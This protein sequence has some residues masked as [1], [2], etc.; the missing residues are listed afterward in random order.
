M[1]SNNF[2]NKIK[3]SLEQRTMQPSSDAWN[4][5]Q[6]N[7]DAP[8]K[9]RSLKRYWVLAI[10][11]GFIGVLLVNVLFFNF[12][13]LPNSTIVNTESATENTIVVDTE[14][15]IKHEVATETNVEKGDELQDVKENTHITTHVL[16]NQ[17]KEPK[18]TKSVKIDSNKNQ[19]VEVQNINTPVLEDSVSGFE[20]KTSVVI[21]DVSE[22]YIENL[23]QQ[24]EQEV[25]ADKLVKNNQQTVDSEQLLEHVENDIEYSFREKVFDVVKTGFVKVKTAVVE[26]NN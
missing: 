13:K 10:A 9:K 6:L 15:N 19:V 4:K 2:E 23:L 26:R 11:A 12:N 20:I 17:V 22:D 18:N 8:Q 7:L 5:L 25:V 3:D 21:Q 24:A 16:V 1:A 14:T